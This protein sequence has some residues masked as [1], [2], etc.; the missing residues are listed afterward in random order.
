MRFAPQIHDF[1]FPIF[2]F[3][4]PPSPQNPQ[5]PVINPQSS[6]ST[7]LQTS[8]FL[9]TATGPSVA[10]LHLATDGVPNSRF[11][12]FSFQDSPPFLR[13]TPSPQ[14]S[15]RSISSKP[16][17]PVPSR[18]YPGYPGYPNP[19]EPSQ[20]RRN[21][22]VRHQPAFAQVRQGTIRQRLQS[23]HLRAACQPVRT[24][25]PERHKQ[26]R[27]FP[28]ALPLHLP[29]RRLTP[30]LTGKT[31][32][33]PN[34]HAGPYT[35]TGRRTPGNLLPSAWVVSQRHLSPVDRT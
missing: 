30:F 8:D 31:S 28:S 3:Q 15:I 13:T 33:T 21:P 29:L 16:Q 22:P 10:A 12:I 27:A 1:R 26:V 11:S 14:S 18:R 35:L 17:P 7:R 9:R 5:S 34:N 23:V 25:D 4:D 2:S 19:T 24:V 32:K 6:I 20:L